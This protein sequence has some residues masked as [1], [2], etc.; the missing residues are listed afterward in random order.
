MTN[1]LQPPQ[2]HAPAVTPVDSRRGL[3][4]FIELVM[5]LLL[6]L[7]ALPLLPIWLPGAKLQRVVCIG[8]G[9]RSFTALSWTWPSGARSRLAARLGLG[10]LPGL[11]NVMRGEMRL[12]GPRPIPVDET[13]PAEVSAWRQSVA[14]GLISLWSLRQRTSIDYGDEWLSDLEQHQNCSVKNELGLIMRRCFA[15]LYA[16]STRF[17]AED[18]ILT[19][20]V[21]VGSYTMEE[22]LD[23]I[24]G[25]LNSSS[26][27]AM[28]VC[29]VNPDCVNI[30]RR[31]AGYRSL[32]N[33]ADLALPDGIGMRIAAN[34]LGTRF[35]QN[36]N[37]TDLF[38][39]LCERLA[40]RGASLYLLGA[41]P[42]ITD[43]VAAWLAKHHPGVRL[44]G[45]QHGYFDTAQTDQV[46][47]SIRASQADVLLVAMGVPMQERWI[48]EHATNCGVRVALGV[49]GLFDFVSGRIPR[50]PIW[51]R[52][53]GLEWTYR[54]IQEPARMWR[55]YLVGNF[56]FLVAIA[57][58]RWIGSADPRSYITADLP[59]FDQSP[60]QAIIIADWPDTPEW[61]NEGDQT[62]ALLPLG[63]RPVIYRVL[64]TLN[65]VNCSEVDVYAAHGISQLSKAL[66]DGK[67]W[68]LTLRIHAVRDFHDTRR[69][70]IRQ[71]HNLEEVWLLRADHWLTADT[72]L[73][74]PA[75]CAWMVVEEDGTLSWSGW[76]R[77]AGKHVEAS[78]A[79]CIDDK[80]TDITWPPDVASVGTVHAY[81]L[82][83]ARDILT[84]QSNWLGRQTSTLE[85]LVET[86]PGIRMAPSA[87]V[88]P[89]AELIPPLE[90]CDR[91]FIGDGVRLGPNVVVG[92]GAHLEGE[93]VVSE[94][95]IDSDVVISGE[96]D[97]D[98]TITRPHGLF[99]VKHGVWLPTRLTGSLIGDARQDTPRITPSPAERVFAIML[100]TIAAIPV[101]TLS[102]L[103]RRMKAVRQ[104]W[105]ALPTVARGQARLIGSGYR[106]S[107]PESLHLAG[108]AEPLTQ[109]LP[110]LIRPSEAMGINEPE[111]AAWADLRWLVDQT[112]RMGLSIVQAWLLLI[113]TNKLPHHQPPPPDS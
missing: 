70:A 113:W 11:W 109:A 47:A 41:K 45:H 71:A 12:C 74:T 110:A 14:P 61:L 62:S 46:V 29:F 59:V 19:D 27:T 31:N 42:G 88:A 50:A 6:A 17:A 15:T 23:L 68:G 95:L 55:R 106:E 22:T 100:W 21:L 93:I 44:A 4:R 75:Q 5:A 91:A 69:R 107:V 79:A 32:V 66:G 57:M 103:S 97:L 77:V 112:P 87:V 108:W 94:S 67:R 35:K 98:Q 26:D 8:R 28:K 48:E 54:L 105:Q 63:D 89:G 51:L 102:P 39:R 82:H 24:D 111:A 25:R 90:I 83:N 13:I 86:K 34:L 65:A 1:N 80:Q 72:L 16:P 49:G 18:R 73:G 53:L 33:R 2:N 9:G 56:S 85:R 104:L 78:L 76:S 96:A 36:V 20:T 92:E 3:P 10:A 40:K 99:D 64:E 101:I 30:A 60:G 84:A 43:Q 58:Q 37:G 7:A 81:R 38:P 52:E